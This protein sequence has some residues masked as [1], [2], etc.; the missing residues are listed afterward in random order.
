M[1]EYYLKGGWVTLWLYAIILHIKKWRTAETE[2]FIKISY[3]LSSFAVWKGK[4]M[5]KQKQN[6][7]KGNKP[8][9]KNEQSKTNYWCML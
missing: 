5:Q 9:N 3:S 4:K 6:D 2:V 1:S 8:T 7:R